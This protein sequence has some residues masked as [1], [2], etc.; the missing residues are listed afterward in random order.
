MGSLVGTESQLSTETAD[1]KKFGDTKQGCRVRVPE[2]EVAAESRP[3]EVKPLAKAR[4]MVSEEKC[5][6]ESIS[7]GHIHSSF[8]QLSR[9]SGVFAQ[10]ERLRKRPGTM[11]KACIFSES[12]TVDDSCCSCHGGR[13]PLGA[14]RPLRVPCE[15]GGKTCRTRDAESLDSKKARKRC[16]IVA[17]ISGLCCLDEASRRGPM[18]GI[19]MKASKA[20]ESRRELCM[21]VMEQ[22]KKS[23]CNSRRGTRRNHCIAEW[24]RV[25]FLQTNLRSSPRNGDRVRQ[26]RA[27][28]S[29]S[30]TTLRRQRRRGRSNIKEVSGFDQQWTELS[31]DRTCFQAFVFGRARETGHLGARSVC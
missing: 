19:S 21:T 28:G 23:I 27:N 3:E 15:G 8:L 16:C 20:F 24:H 26:L 13:Q 25:R 12:G 2:F 1:L 29:P 31:S 10:A 22:S 11:Q 5:G 18:S 30:T 14:L 6:A 9:A 17:G 4:T 7:Y